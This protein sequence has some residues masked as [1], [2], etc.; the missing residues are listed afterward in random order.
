MVT[1]QLF[2][3]AFCHRDWSAG[4]AD[5]ASRGVEIAASAFR[6]APHPPSTHCCTQAWQT[7]RIVPVVAKITLY[8]VISGSLTAL[9]FV[10]VER[11]LRRRPERRVLQA[12]VSVSL[13]R[14][15]RV[16]GGRDTTQVHP[17]ARAMM[18]PARSLGRGAPGQ[19]SRGA[20]SPGPCPIVGYESSHLNV[21]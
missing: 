5:G 7:P 9:A 19:A 14:P 3:V 11:G 6:P 8:T 17:R 12:F 13:L 1:T 15:S 18:K 10:T 21:V 16:D 20:T 2:R 4:V